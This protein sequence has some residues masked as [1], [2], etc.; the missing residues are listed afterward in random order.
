MYAG[1]TSLSASRE[2]VSDV[3]LNKKLALD[4]RRIS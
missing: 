1:D 4:E 3:S 2:S